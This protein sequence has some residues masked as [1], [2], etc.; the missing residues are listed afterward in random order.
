M[1]KLFTPFLLLLCLTALVA[2]G[3]GSNGSDGRVLKVS[4]AFATQIEEPWNGVVHGALLEAESDGEISYSWTAGI[5]YDDG[6][7]EGALRR[8]IETEQP[9][10]IF[11]DAFG[12][13]DAARRVAAD[14]PK[15]AFVMGSANSETAPNFSV[16]D[17]WIHEPAYLCGMLA[18]GLTKTNKIG[19]VGAYPVAE[20]NRLANAFIAGAREVNPGVESLVT[21]I[22]SWYDPAAAG[23]ATAQQI[24]AGAD[25]FFAER[26]GVIQTAASQQLLSLGN[27]IDQRD[28]A[29]QEVVSSSVWNMRPTV[30]EVIRSVRTNTYAASNL[31]QYSM[32][33]ADGAA[34]APINNKV[35]GGIP[36]ALEAAVLRR[37]VAIRTGE[38]LVNIDES[39]PEGTVIR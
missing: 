29:P 26:D 8:I 17:N 7:M 20:V 9:D 3:D 16:F 27:I 1:A 37:L 39:V 21:Y 11:G 12:N 10:I 36:V 38:F 30:G 18:G 13:E 14:Y 5:G 35:R 19:I 6:A 15:I 2:C 4:G 25:V 22:S 34:L 33:A 24:S 32:M 31:R 23:A 28:V